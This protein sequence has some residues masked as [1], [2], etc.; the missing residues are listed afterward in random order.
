MFKFCQFRMANDMSMPEFFRKITIKTRDYDIFRP[1]FV[2]IWLKFIN[3][4]EIIHVRMNIKALL[5]Q[6][7]KQK[8]KY[9]EEIR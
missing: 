6:Y 7:F 9:K 2:V 5:E 1:I 8:H 4:A 3:F